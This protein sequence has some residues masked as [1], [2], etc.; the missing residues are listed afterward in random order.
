MIVELPNGE[1]ILLDAV[2]QSAGWNNQ[3]PAI[4]DF[5]F[6]ITSNLASVR[7]TSV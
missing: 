7:S 2:M 3:K 1:T 4:Y 5:R 6:S